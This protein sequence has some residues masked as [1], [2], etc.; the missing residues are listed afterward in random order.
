MMGFKKYDR[1]MSFMGMELRRTL[2]KT[3]TQRLLANIDSHINSVNSNSLS[4]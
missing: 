2:G 4:W 1:G 3:M